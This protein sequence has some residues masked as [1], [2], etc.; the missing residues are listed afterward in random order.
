MSKINPDKWKEMVQ[1]I[2]K[3]A[4]LISETM[5]VDQKN[6][7]V[8]CSDGWDRTA[9]LCSLSQILLD[10]YYRTLQGFEVVIEKEWISFGYQFS[11]RGGNFQD[12]DSSARKT[13]PVFIQ[14]LDCVYQLVEQFP[15]A[16]QFNS[17]LLTFLATEV[18]SCRFGSFLMDNEWQRVKDNNLG[19]NLNKVTTSIWTYVNDHCVEFLNP[20]YS[21]ISYRLQP[22]CDLASI[23]LWKEHFLS[24]SEIIN[25]EATNDAVGPFN[26]MNSVF[27]G[28]INKYIENQ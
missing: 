27:I 4:C 14:F 7:L 18:Y 26:N 5:F 10:P 8:H 9:Q 6:V 3:T 11:T 13:S 22:H 17:H 19:V 15:T 12:A 1:T 20:F 25:D 2:L 16:F 24:W 21:Q 23:K 28:Y